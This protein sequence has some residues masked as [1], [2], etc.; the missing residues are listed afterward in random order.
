[1]QQAVKKKRKAATY[2]FVS[3]D[4]CSSVVEKV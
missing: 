1:M 3:S 4:K 2:L